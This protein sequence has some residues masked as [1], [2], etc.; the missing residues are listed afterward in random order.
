M[1]CVVRVDDDTIKNPPLLEHG[2]ELLLPKHGAV[3][4]VIRNRSVVRL[5]ISHF[6][7]CQALR[8][9]DTIQ[10]SQNQQS[11]YHQRQ[12]HQARK[13]NLL[14]IRVP[15]VVIQILRLK[16]LVV[17]LLWY[18]VVEQRVVLA[19]RLLR[20]R[21]RVSAHHQLRLRCHVV[22]CR[23]VFRVRDRSRF[24][25]LSYLRQRQRQSRH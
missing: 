6:L 25:I 3:V 14:R 5:L 13:V 4:D 23:E 10:V 19:P 22:R 11:V 7:S 9:V 20:L 21:R 18:P 24:A 12:K 15:G 17:T 2:P 1:L 8:Q 16:L